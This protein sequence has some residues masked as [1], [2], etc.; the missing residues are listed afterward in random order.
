LS[1]RVLVR[2]VCVLAAHGRSVHELRRHKSGD[3]A[4]DRHAREAVNA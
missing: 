4:I 1:Y 3:A 2:R